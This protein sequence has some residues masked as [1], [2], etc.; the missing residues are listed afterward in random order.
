MSRC[1]DRVGQRVFLSLRILS[2]MAP[3]LNCIGAIDAA[4][5]ASFW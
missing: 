1:P 3:Q 5:P 4:K 2:Q